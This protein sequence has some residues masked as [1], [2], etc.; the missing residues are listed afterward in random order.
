MEFQVQTINVVGINVALKA[1]GNAMRTD[2]DTDYLN[3]TDKDLK[4]GWS[5]GPTECGAGHDNFLM[6]ITVQFNIWAPLYMWKQI[7]RYHF[8]DIISS[9]STMHK[10]IQF[11]AKE[12][13]VEETDKIILARY[14]DLLDEYLEL[15]EKDPKNPELNAKWRTLVA[16]LPSGFILG[17]TMTTNYRQ[18]KTIYN[19]RKYHKLKEWQEFCN[20]CEALP[21]FKEL[22]LGE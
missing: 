19:Q 8:L 22:C 12:Q 7:Q 4:R 5:L 2:M 13:C 10:L 11:R 16:S 6:G 21:L 3:L 20:W 17:A 14:E 9:Q 15:K 18:L 1:A